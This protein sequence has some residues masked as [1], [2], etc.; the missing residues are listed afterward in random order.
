MMKKLCTLL[1][2]FLLLLP[3]AE[4]QSSL[5]ISMEQFKQQFLDAIN[6]KRARGCNCGTA[7]MKPTTPLIWNEQLANAAREHAK[8]M[9]RTHYFSHES[10]D[11]RDMETR[12]LNAGYTYKGY[13]RYAIGENIAFNQRSIDE[14]LTGWFKSNGHCENLMNPAFTEIGI[15]ENHYYWVQDFGGR[16]KFG[17]H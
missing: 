3:F 7:Y 15:A 17:Y 6:A 9:Y 5:N 8:D 13:Q 16:V 14:V 4:G 12:L 10:K 1:L 2:A 11:G